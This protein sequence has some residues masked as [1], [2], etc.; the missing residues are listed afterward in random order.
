MGAAAVEVR[1]GIRFR[2]L[3][4]C[5]ACGGERLTTALADGVDFETGLGAFAVRECESCG[6]QFTTPQPL[7]EDVHLLYADRDAHDFET[8]YGNRP[9]RGV[10]S[11]YGRR[12]WLP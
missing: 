9:W 8:S 4:A 10:S 12:S 3:T 6:I 11:V 1:G 2:T 5:P 7:P